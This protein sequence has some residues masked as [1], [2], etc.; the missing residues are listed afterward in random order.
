ML[1]AADYGCLILMLLLSAGVYAALRQPRAWLA[2]LA[3]LFTAALFILYILSVKTPW[4]D[5]LWI[6][7]LPHPSAV[8]CQHSAVWGPLAAVLLGVAPKLEKRNQRAVTVVA[9]LV[10][11]WWAYTVAQLIISPGER[12]ESLWVGEVLIQSTGSTCI[13]AACCTYLRTEGIAMDEPEAV[14]LGLIGR[15]GGTL[16]NA[17]RI[18]R[19]SAPERKLSFRRLS[20]EE[21]FAH[22]GGWLVTATRLG[23]FTGHAIVVSPLPDGERLFIRDPIAGEY[24]ADYSEFATG[25]LGNCTWYGE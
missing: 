6:A 25:W 15:E 21:L 24:I 22:R 19:L 2:A 23:D 8:V 4:F 20:R 1:L 7:L 16:A 10:C 18:L 12:A 5:H 11:G 17:W 3:L 9:L 14:R 13:A